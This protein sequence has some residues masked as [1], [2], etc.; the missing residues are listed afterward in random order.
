VLAE[1]GD[2]QGDLLAP[3]RS[4]GSEC[5]QRIGDVLNDFLAELTMIDAT[6]RFP[7]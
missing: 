6:G 3:A 1:Q 2:F 4:E 5:R 7:G